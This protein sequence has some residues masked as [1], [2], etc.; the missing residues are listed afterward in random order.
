MQSQYQ[1]LDVWKQ[2]RW[3][4]QLIYRVT[5]LFPSDERFGLTQQMRRAAVSI[6]SN[7]A[8]G[9]GRETKKDRRHF[10]HMA[11][12]SAYELDTQ[13]ILAMDLGFCDTE[14]TTELREAIELCLR[15]LQGLIR[16]TNR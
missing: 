8:E 7:I 4:V 16:S 3:T 15:L 14:K 6:S 10:Y 13:V 5:K 1:D 9:C 2:A 12:G 11:R